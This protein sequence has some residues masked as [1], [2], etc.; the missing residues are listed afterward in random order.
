M[1]SFIVPNA[2]ADVVL[3]LGVDDNTGLTPSADSVST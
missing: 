2:L 1:E 3:L